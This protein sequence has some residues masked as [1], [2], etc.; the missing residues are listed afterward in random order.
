MERKRNLA[1][2]LSGVLSMRVCCCLLALYVV[3]SINPLVA[4][5]PENKSSDVLDFHIVIAGDIMTHTP[6]IRAAK[7]SSRVYDFTSSFR[8]VAPMIARAD[9]AIGNL[10]TTFGGEPYRGYPQFSSPDTL[11][12]NLKE[13]GFDVLTTAN[14]HAA[15]TYGRGIKRTL[16]VLADAGIQT[17]GSYR[18]AEERDK[19]APLMVDAGSL[20]LAVLAYT[21]GTNG[22]SVKPPTDVALI[23][24]VQMAVEISKAKKMGADY[25]LVMMHWGIE[26][27]I[28]PVSAQRVIAQFLHR[29]GVDAIIGSHPHVVQDAEVIPADKHGDKPTYVIYSMGNFISNQNDTPCRGGMLLTLRLS[30]DHA[31]APIR[32][33]PHYQY[34][35]VSKRDRGGEPYTL[36]PIAL[37]GDVPNGV[38]STDIPAIEQFRRYYRGISLS[39]ES[40]YPFEPAR[41][42]IDWG[43]WLRLELKLK[44]IR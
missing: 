3:A 13:V 18:N 2:W 8:Y 25:I 37:T 1:A 31:D 10:E 34:V 20:R 17:T 39:Q 5:S 27:T 4:Q 44:P 16:D 26:Y 9:L 33:T 40:T 7:K 12:Y 42:S 19:R 24:T 32:T 28:K 38:L 22:I 23:D 30:R 43:Q 15:D 6:Q 36:Y 11:A 35:W 41:P 21:Y 29:Q 14:N